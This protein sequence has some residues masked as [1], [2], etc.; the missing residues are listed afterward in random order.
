MITNKELK[1]CRTC[2]ST[3]LTKYLDLGMIPLVNQLGKT[4][5][6][7][8]NMAQFP[9]EILFC[10]D[11]GL[12]Q[13]S[14]VVN[15]KIMFSDYPYRSGVSKPFVEH[16]S[17]LADYCINK[18]S[19]N[20][21][22]LVMDIASNDGTLLKAF[23]KI[24][25]SV[26]GIEPAK[27]LAEIA[28]IDGVPTMPDFWSESVA[29]KVIEVFGKVKL[30]LGTNVFA[31]VDNITEFLLNAKNCLA[32][33]GVIVLEFPYLMNLIKANAFDTVYH[34]HLSYFSAKPLNILAKKCGLKIIDITEIPIH[35]GSIRVEFTL[36]DSIIC[37]SNGK[38][39]F[40]RLVEKVDGYDTVDMYLEWGTK[41]KGVIS[42]I[43]NQLNTI[44]QSGKSIA[45]FG[46]AAKGCIL[47][48]SINANDN[49]IDYIVDDTPEK[50]WEILTWHW[51]T[52]C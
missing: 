47:L 30:I 49:L 48:N 36:E 35:G 7:A 15:P 32:N 5:Y 21:K 29:N 3:N 37:V 10:S 18:F 26:L 8:M 20:K 6:D 40:F 38:Y 19:L 28:N 34:E 39:K 31:H 2:N 13:L 27:N 12:S 43:K 17:E 25:L 52:Y 16:C 24:G 23:D 46:A 41:V 42:D 9:L 33:N 22:D 11:C 44:K 45:A 4:K 1:N 51:D 50:N 14:Q